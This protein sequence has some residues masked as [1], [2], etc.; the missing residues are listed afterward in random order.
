MQQLSGHLLDILVRNHIGLGRCAGV[1]V[2]TNDNSSSLQQ[3]FEHFSLGWVKL[4]DDLFDLGGSPLGQVLDGLGELHEF[5]HL[6]ERHLEG[7][8][9][10]GE[11]KLNE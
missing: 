5:I 6:E 4:R 2:I 3:L 9:D 1:V 11:F 10:Q 7:I 8:E